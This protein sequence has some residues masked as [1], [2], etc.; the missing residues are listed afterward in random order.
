M[1]TL[2][3]AFTTYPLLPATP[4]LLPPTYLPLPITIHLLPTTPYPL[5]AAYYHLPT[6]QSFLCCRMHFD[7]FMP[8]MLSVLVTFTGVWIPGMAGE[9]LTTHYSPLSTYYVYIRITH[10]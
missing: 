6:R 9:L 7:Y 3:L 1:M 5:P 2:A 8:A 4:Y 10:L